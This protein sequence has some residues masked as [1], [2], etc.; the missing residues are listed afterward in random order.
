MQFQQ[1][2]SILVETDT[3]ELVA[4]GN[5][6]LLMSKFMKWDLLVL[7]FICLNQLPDLF[8]NTLFYQCNGSSQYT[9]ANMCMWKTKLDFQLGIL[10]LS[11]SSSRSSLQRK[12][13]HV[14]KTALCNSS[15]S[16]FSTIFSHCWDNGFANPTS[17]TQVVLANSQITNILYHWDLGWHIHLPHTNTDTQ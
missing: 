9:T 10:F 6:H 16:A 2:H 15:Y 1:Q 3:P 13:G 5:G 17:T 4:W 14:G 11:P 7:T 12:I 8:A